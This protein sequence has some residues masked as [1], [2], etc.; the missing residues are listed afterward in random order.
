M[1]EAAK[2]A[3]ASEFIEAMQGGYDAN[4]FESGTSLSGGQ[5]QR[6]AIARAML[7]ETIETAAMEDVHLRS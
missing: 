7:R 2:H 5:R 1:Q 6:L 4:V 3:H